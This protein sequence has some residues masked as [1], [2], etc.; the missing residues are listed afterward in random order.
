MFVINSFQIPHQQELKF[1]V[2]SNHK[3][4]LNFQSIFI[5]PKHPSSVLDSSISS[6][7]NFPIDFSSRELFLA[8]STSS[9]STSHL[10]MIIATFS[11]T[12]A[13]AAARK[14]IIFSPRSVERMKRKLFI[15]APILF[16]KISFELIL[17]LLC[18][19]DTVC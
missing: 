9:T 7:S 5:Y 1:S 6:F 11:Q 15:Y 17:S 2:L 12:T 8:H 18:S 4:F 3:R 10:D 16:L 13:A 19:R 14:C